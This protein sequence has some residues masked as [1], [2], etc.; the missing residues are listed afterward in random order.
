M[1]ALPNMIRAAVRVTIANSEDLSSNIYCVANPQS[2]PISGKAVLGRLAPIGW[3]GQVIQYGHTESLGGSLELY[4]SAQ[5]IWRFGNARIS[6]IDDV[7]GF[8]SAF[9]FPVSLGKAAPEAIL[10]WPT[11]ASIKVGIEDFK[12]NYTAF[13][14]K[15]N[16]R[17]ASISIQYVSTRLAFRSGK[18]QGSYVWTNWEKG[19]S[20]G[21]TGRGTN[22]KGGS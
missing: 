20:S 9:I 12:V 4:V 14:R 21:N 7:V 15:L 22:F 6:N 2:L 1:V 17:V 11:I 19:G 8:F 5:H 16:A 18:D 3:S 10:V 13:D